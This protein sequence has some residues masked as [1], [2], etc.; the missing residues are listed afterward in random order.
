MKGLLKRVMTSA[1]V[2]R[3]MDRFLAR[4]YGANEAYPRG[5]YYSPLPDIAAVRAQADLLFRRDIAP[6]PGIDLREDAQ[7]QLLEELAAFY[8]EF[9]W[10]EE[11]V[12]ERRYY[13]SNGMFGFGSGFWLYAMLRRFRPR[14]VVEIG[15]GFSSALMLDT[16][17]R[18]L[19]GAVDF[20]FIDPFNERLLGLLR[21]ADAHRTRII[22]D[23]VQNADLATFEA[24]GT[25]DILFV[26]SSHVCKVGSDVNFIFNHVFPLL[27]PGVIVHI[28][29][30]YWPFEYPRHWIV[31]RGWAWNEAYLLRAFL[32]YNERFEIIQFNNFLACR[33]PDLIEELMPK[34]LKSPGSSFW[35]RRV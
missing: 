8:P 20:T 9:D 25:D 17:E 15:S 18:F 22:K 28:H 33:F 21:P 3:S 2:L 23:V 5:H 6:L 11:Q 32:Q 24:L 26:D 14:R 31:D 34:V 12:P 30:I 29:D 4:R 19:D 7:R 16:S 35:M 13:T 1:P 27:R 10:P